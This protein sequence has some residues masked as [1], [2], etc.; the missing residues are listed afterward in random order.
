VLVKG[1][2]S[3]CYGQDMKVLDDGIDIAIDVHMLWN[4]WVDNFILKI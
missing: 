3:W 2:V 1:N 4:Y